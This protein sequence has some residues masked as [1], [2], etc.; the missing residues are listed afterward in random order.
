[1]EIKNE[2]FCTLWKLPSSVRCFQE[3]ILSTQFLRLLISGKAL[4]SIM[5]TSASHD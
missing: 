2:A 3:L 1:M 4:K 5:V